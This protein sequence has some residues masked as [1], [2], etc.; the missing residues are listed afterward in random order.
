M[1]NKLVCVQQYIQFEKFGYL[2]LYFH[3]PGTA[4]EFTTCFTNRL[5]SRLLSW[6]KENFLVCGVFSLKL[7]SFICGCLLFT[8]QLAD[9]A[10]LEEVIRMVL[11]IINSCVT[12]TLHHNPN[13]VY[14]L[15]HRRE[16]FAQFRTHPTF[17]DIIQNIDTVSRPTQ[18]LVLHR[19][20][21]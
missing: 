3:L 19:R 8:F 11:E 15:L 17:H 2:I 21:R 5:D 1:S 10:I 16:L 20:P 4:V 14:T 9:L 13:L 6:Y 7:V 12:N 18:R